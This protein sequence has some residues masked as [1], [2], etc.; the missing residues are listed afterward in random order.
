MFRRNRWKE[1]LLSLAAGQQMVPFG[2]NQAVLR[3]LSQQI[4]ALRAAEARRMAVAPTMQL[5]RSD[6]DEHGA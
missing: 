6:V 2:D 1:M 5:G 3:N 4:W